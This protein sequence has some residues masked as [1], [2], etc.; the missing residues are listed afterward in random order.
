MARGIRQLRGG[1]LRLING[2][3]VT[4]VLGS[5]AA[6]TAQTNIKAT[7][8]DRRGNS[9]NVSKFAF[10]DRNDIEYYVG[11]LRRVKPLAKIER[12]LLGGE[13]NDEEKPITVF[14]RDGETEK[15]TILTGSG[16]APR[17][18]D[19][20]YGGSSEISFTGVS[21]YGPFIMRLNEVREVK[22]RHA[23]KIAAAKP[24]SLNV[25]LVTGE[26]KRFDLD[27][28]RYMGRRSI[29]FEQGGVRRSIAMD[30]IDRIDFTVSR[31]LEERRPV[32]IQLRSGRTLQGTVEISMVRLPGETDKNYYTRQNEV[33]TGNSRRFGPFAIGLQKVKLI[34]F[35]RTA[36]DSA[37][38]SEGNANEM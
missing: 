37:T 35:Q 3:L 14:L 1:F 20:F 24:E 15:G 36:L 11:D 28:L 21:D 9:Y 13:R 25:I 8:I 7:L 10:K 6:S 29:T 4:A 2:L 26:G 5:A 34:R 38:A 27:E 17:T 18:Q 30:K 31:A 32:T 33:F 22:F 19:S 16:S 23:T 12:L